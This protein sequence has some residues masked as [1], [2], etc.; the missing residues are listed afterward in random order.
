[1][2]PP[3]LMAFGAGNVLRPAFQLSF[4]DLGS[5]E[6]STVE[7]MGAVSPT[8]TR[9]TVAWTKLASGL[10]A[11]VASGVARSFYTGFTTA[12]G[13]YAGYLAEGAGTQLVTPTAD[14]RDM[15]GV[16]W[17]AVTMT[18]A[19]TG[20]GIDG[21]V[22]A[23]TRLT[24][25]GAGATVLHLLVAAASDRT[26]S[27]W[28]R[29]VTG[30]GTVKLVQGAT[31]SSDFASSINSSTY[32]QVVLDA[33]VDVTLLG[34]GIELGTSGDVIEVDFNQFEAGAFAT[35]PMASAGA[36]RNAD[37]LTYP[38]SPWMSASRGTFYAEAIS[39][40]TLAGSFITVVGRGSAVGNLAVPI[41]FSLS[42]TMV[43]YIG[44]GVNGGNPLSAAQTFP[45]TSQKKLV[46]TGIANDVQGAINGVLGAQDTTQTAFNP[47]VDIAIG[48]SA[49][50]SLLYGGIARVMYW[51]SRLPNATLQA[52]TA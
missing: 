52:L 11:E 29:R 39:N 15:T 8:F 2:L 43:F 20:T 3:L 17:A 5:G 48:Y 14:I 37:V 16:G 26:Y 50:G 7:D 45:F 47:P 18:V 41:Q 22:N 13:T 31:K 44:D 42:G 23:C 12:A 30:T 19:K 34:Y 21:T 4:D 28:I 1:M 6:V 36:A 32:T 46:V 35:T 24:A 27:A 38:T 25:T 9:A 49:V 40:S 51:P 33:T 10:W